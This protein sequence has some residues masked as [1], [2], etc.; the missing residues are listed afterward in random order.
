MIRRILYPLNLSNLFLVAS[1]VASLI[2]AIIMF[3]ALSGSTS[4][5]ARVKGRRKT[6]LRLLT[7][8][9][10]IFLAKKKNER[11]RKREREREEEGKIIGDGK[12]RRG[13]R[14]HSRGIHAVSL[15]RSRRRT[16]LK[17]RKRRR[18]SPGNRSQ[19]RSR[20]GKEHA[21]ACAWEN[22]PRIAF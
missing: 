22:S 17:I 13:P 21:V 2:S 7:M 20:S 4:I 11:V 9:E 16:V 5:R 18:V 6:C 19:F 12:W 15:Y 1:Y 3:H 10:E 14:G 8:E